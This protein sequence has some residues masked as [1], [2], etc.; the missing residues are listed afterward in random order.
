M[1]E[2]AEAVYETMSGSR[3]PGFC[4]PGV[5]NLYEKGAICWIANKEMHNAYWR[6]CDR[7]GNPEQEDEDGKEMIQNFLTMEKEMAIHMFLKGYEF[8]KNGCPPYVS[9]YPKGKM[10]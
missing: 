9:I 4:V 6:I 1:K 2:Y 10:E 7:L 5:E 8:A 3:L